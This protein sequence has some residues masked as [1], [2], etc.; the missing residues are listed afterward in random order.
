MLRYLLPVLSIG[1]FL[2]M[3]SVGQAI[4]NCNLLPNPSFE[5]QNVAQP[6]GYPN[7]I[8]GNYSDYNEV[9][10]WQAFGSFPGNS[11]Y[12]KPTYY[13]T[14][15]PA[16]SA[17]NPFT[18][19]ATN[20]YGSSFQP[21]NYNPSLHN[22]AL[23]I[24]A[25]EYGNSSPVNIVQYI[26]PISPLSLV[27]GATYYASFQAYR[28]SAPNTAVR[29]GMNLSQ[30][31]PQA[32]AALTSIQSPSPLTNYEW[33][34]VSG[35]ITLPNSSS[36]P[37]YVTIGNLAPNGPGARPRYYID[38]VELY[39]IP[40]A[41]LPISRCT[42][43]AP[44]TIGEGC[45]IPDATYAWTEA[46][47]NTPF[48]RTIQTGVSPTS[49]TNYTLTVTL[50]D[51][52]IF[53]SSVKVTVGPAYPYVG[54][55]DMDTDDCYGV[56]HFRIYN[57][58]PNVMYT[59]TNIRSAVPVGRILTDT[60]IVKGGGA[61]DG[62]FTLKAAN[63]CGNIT[64]DEIQASYPCV[65]ISTAAQRTT[66]YPNPTTETLTLPTG[67]E[68]ATLLNSQGNVVQRSD[69]SG[70]LNVQKLPAGSYNLQMR[71]NGKLINQRIEVKH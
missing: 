1:V 6:S 49:T 36:D 7:N 24:V 4:N 55:V 68:A 47:S 37:W 66:A 3:Q 45:S 58:D 23:S 51:K 11:T 8:S 15:A 60:F 19:P 63:D 59:V 27:P 29:L 54:Q 26:A 52:T 70:R 17:T 20:P 18:S 56:A 10:G 71:Q 9:T 38:E 43:S 13:A 39:K 61:T 62:A 28:S 44:V 48:A 31:G 69:A 33:T 5:Q 32:T 53:T 35:K 41:G 64:T 14:N 30:G 65:G 25:A 67:M 21:Y 16:G 46:G 34:R 2:P 22:G 40:T 50:P 42:N 12:G 57:Y